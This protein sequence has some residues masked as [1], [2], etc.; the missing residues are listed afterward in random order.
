VLDVFSRI[1]LGTY[2]D[3]F[4]QSEVTVAID[5]SGNNGL[6]GEIK[7]P[8]VRGEGDAQERGPNF[9]DCATL[10]CDLHVVT[11]RSTRAI[12]KPDILEN[13]RLRGSLSHSHTAA[14]RERRE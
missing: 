11:G 7:Y 1:I 5:E 8:R 2:C 6:A 10:N 14:E 4:N 9:R 3:T 12:Y 13:N